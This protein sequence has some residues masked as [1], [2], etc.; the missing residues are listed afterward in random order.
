SF[1]SRVS[2]LIPL[3]IAKTR[4]RERAPTAAACG[5]ARGAQVGSRAAGRRDLGPA[6]EVSADDATWALAGSPGSS[7][8]QVWGRVLTRTLKPEGDGEHVRGEE[9][10]GQIIDLLREG[11]SLGS[12]CRCNL[13]L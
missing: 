5:L 7:G 3:H 11:N 8:T 4:V 2:S 1:F 13:Y 6:V 12:V 10:G 9:M